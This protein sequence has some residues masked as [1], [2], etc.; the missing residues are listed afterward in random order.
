MRAGREWFARPAPEVARSLI[1]QARSTIRKMVSRA[2]SLN[3]RPGSTMR[4]RTPHLPERRR[5]TRSN[6]GRYLYVPR[7][8]GIHAM[9]NIVTN[10]AG[11]P[12]AVLIR[13]VEPIEGMDLMRAR[14]GAVP[15]RALTRG[16]GNLCQAFD[17]RLITMATIS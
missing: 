6:A 17:F 11:D 13:A 16:P 5:E 7:S 4:R 8:Y 2:A 3:Q 14:R 9:F 15:D 10:A 1:G 12:G